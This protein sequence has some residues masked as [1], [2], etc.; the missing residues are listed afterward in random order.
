MYQSIIID[1]E[2]NLP[3]AVS[4]Q[5]MTKFTTNKKK[6]MLKKE[7]KK[8]VNLEDLCNVHNTLNGTLRINIRQNQLYLQLSNIPSLFLLIIK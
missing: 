5:C 8:E 1:S 6:K 4:F 7:K 2:V 3:M